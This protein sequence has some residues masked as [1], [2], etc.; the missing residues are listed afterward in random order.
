MLRA[1]FPRT[2]LIRDLK[3]VRPFTA[4]KSHIPALSHVLLSCEDGVAT[5]TATDLDNWCTI[6]MT[7]AAVVADGALGVPAKELLQVLSVYDGDEVLLEQVDAKELAVE[8]G[9][10][11]FTLQG[12]T[13]EDFPAQPLV[14]PQTRMEIPMDDL[15]EVLARVGFAIAQE[16]SRF[17]LNGALFV[18][19]RGLLTVTATDGHRLSIAAVEADVD[20]AEGDKGQ[21]L[22]TQVLVDEMTRMR[23]LG[24]EPVMFK[25]NDHRLQAVAGS[26]LIQCRL[27]DGTF[28]DYERVLNQ[29][30]KTR[31]VVRSADVHRGCQLALKAEVKT[32]RFEFLSDGLELTG[33]NPD[34]GSF[35]TVLEATEMLNGEWTLGISPEYLDQAVRACGTHEVAILGKDEN[36]VVMVAPIG[37]IPV[38]RHQ[39]LIMPMRV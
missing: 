23:G 1:V 37:E 5:L 30:P 6:E 32:L 33:S 26:R 35:R 22:V 29:E 25:I 31:A 24:S 36:T 7:A 18:L 20:L 9:G 38:Q 27:L 39:Q 15:Q 10:S 12:V 28:P 8:E 17:Q 4:R 14:E 34:L 13:I 21:Y 3:A 2:D 16:E 19:S 11:R